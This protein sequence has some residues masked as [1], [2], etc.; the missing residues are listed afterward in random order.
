MCALN[1]NVMDEA[2]KWNVEIRDVREGQVELQREEEARLRKKREDFV[3]Q[4]E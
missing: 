3:K 4:M 1:M 2:C